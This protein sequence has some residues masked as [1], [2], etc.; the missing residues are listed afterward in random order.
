M[1][2]P[3]PRRAMRG[4]FRADQMKESDRYELSNGHAI[5]CA[6]TG[7]DGSQGMGL[8]FEVLDT[9][10]AV[11]EAGV[12]PGYS[13]EPG[14]LR[15]PDVG[16]GNVPARPGWI[17]GAP[18][19]AVEYSGTGQDE[20][21]LQQ[22]I[23]EFLAAGTR[24]V[25]VIRLVGPR[26]VEVYEPGIPPRTVGAGALLEAPGILRNAVPVE[27]LWDREHAHEVVLRNMLQRR[28]YADLGAVREEGREQGA[29]GERRRTV[30]DLCEVL[31][32][33]WTEGRAAI[34]RRAGLAELAGLIDRLKRERSWPE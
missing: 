26:R 29:E 19:L 25:W 28:G 14:T 7:G 3:L 11:Q 15:A 30:R 16:V 34:A 22:K 32:L 8:A 4:P 20:A 23:V 33:P 21:E 1:S 31:G 9:D 12:D 2:D 10:P 27:A 13:P 5:F 24:F 17:P 6:P 18:P